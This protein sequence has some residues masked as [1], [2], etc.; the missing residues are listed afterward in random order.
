MTAASGTAQHPKA[1]PGARN[2]T[3]TTEFPALASITP[4]ERPGLKVVG[5]AGRS[6]STPGPFSGVPATPAP[7]TRRKTGTPHPLTGPA[8]S[9]MTWDEI[10]LSGDVR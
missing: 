1:A 2:T 4:E 9:G 10:A 5:P 3:P 6:T 8:P 7:E